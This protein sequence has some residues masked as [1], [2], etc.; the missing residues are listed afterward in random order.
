MAEDDVAAGAA[1]EDPEASATSPCIDPTVPTA[2]KG[3]IPTSSSLS[4]WPV[5]ESAMTV[6]APQSSLSSS[7]GVGLCA[8]GDW[9]VSDL[10]SDVA[11]SS[12]SSSCMGSILDP[13]L[14][15]SDFR[16]LSSSAAQMNAIS[17]KPGGFSNS[18][19]LVHEEYCLYRQSKT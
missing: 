17:S 14:R 4:S 9:P 8:N 2:V 18:S 7:K 19:Q 12:W 6:G 1:T 13:S 3:S 15:V 16:D 5:S 11:A 10:L